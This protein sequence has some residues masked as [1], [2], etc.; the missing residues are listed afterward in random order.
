MP[1]PEATYEIRDAEHLSRLVATAFSQR[2]KTVRNALRTV[3]DEAMLESVG[4]DPGLRPEAIAIAE[5]V[6]LSNTL[7]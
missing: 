7:E 5:Y 1:L 4:I 3:A 6:R 2:R